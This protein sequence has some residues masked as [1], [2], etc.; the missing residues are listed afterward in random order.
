M[1]K[2]TVVRCPVF[3]KMILRI[4]LISYIIPEKFLS[5]ENSM[6]I[7]KL[8][9][10][11]VRYN[12]LPTHWIPLNWIPSFGDI[13]KN[14]STMQLLSHL[15]NLKRKKVTGNLSTKPQTLWNVWRDAIDEFKF[16][17]N[18]DECTLIIYYSEIDIIWWKNL[19]G[20]VKLIIN[21]VKFV[22]VC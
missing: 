15:W 17:L 12:C 13:V 9:Q 1:S 8:S 3:F 5:T 11:I 10:S 2:R 4:L 16:V 7:S 19:K 18:K 6:S 14:V 20:S 21:F 22:V